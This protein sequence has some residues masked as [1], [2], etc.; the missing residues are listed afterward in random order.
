MKA[1]YEDRVAHKS[2]IIKM[3]T[4]ETAMYFFFSKCAMTQVTVIL[5]QAATQEQRCV[6]YTVRVFAQLVSRKN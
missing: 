6:E 5:I 4:C 3:V 1:D 2:L